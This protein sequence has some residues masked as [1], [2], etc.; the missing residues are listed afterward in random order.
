MAEASDTNVRDVRDLPAFG[1]AV[2]LAS[3]PSISNTRDR[4]R[5]RFVF[6]SWAAAY[7]AA[8]F[9]VGTVVVSSLK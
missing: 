3:I 4:R 6:V 5:R 7:A 1:D 9:I 2:V 8:L